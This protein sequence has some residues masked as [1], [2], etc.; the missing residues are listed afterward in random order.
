MRPYTLVAELTHRCP[1]RCPYCSNPVELVGA[2]IETRHWLRVIEQAAALGVAQLHFSGGEP[3]LRDDLEELVRAART[4]GL[5]T[6]LITSGIPLD[7][8]RLSALREAGLDCVQVSIQDAEAARSDRIAGARSF[9]QKLAVARWTRELGMAL[10]INVVLHRENLDRIAEHIALAESLSAERIELANTQYHGWA[11]AN[12]AALLP[13]R[14]Q[15]ER[16]R[17][18]AQAAAARLTGRMEVLFVLP[19]HFT[20][21]P[22]ACMGGWARRYIVV[23][24]DGVALPCHNARSIAGLEWRNVRDQSLADIWNDSTAFQRFRG[25]AW[26]PE[27]CKSCDKRAVDFGGCR[28]QAFA[29]TGDAAATDPACSLSPQHH[30]IREVR[31]Q[32]AGGLDG[33]VYRGTLRR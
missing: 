5:Y 18:V 28:C 30:L 8:E 23:A 11:Q 4:H 13:E 2:E 27:P 6:N 21:H 32:A 1:L 22:K 33:F 25:E 10:T 16:A 20:P 26:M 31:A 12:R 17:T 9:E 24:P 14:A 3:L 7:R 29:L 15:L 19:D